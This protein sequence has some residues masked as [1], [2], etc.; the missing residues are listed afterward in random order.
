MWAA[1]ALL[2][3][4]VTWV[5]AIGA[6]AGPAMAGG[7][8]IA[9]KLA[10]A[11]AR[12]VQMATAILY[13]ELARLTANGEA[14]V[15]G[16][17]MRRT[18]RLSAMLAVLLVA[19][20]TLGGSSLIWLLA[21]RSYEFASLFLAILGLAAALELS[22]FAL[23]PLLTAHGR[24]TRVLV[25]RIVGAVAY[26]IALAA[27]LPSAGTAGAAAAAVLSALV[28]RIG[29]GREVRKILRPPAQ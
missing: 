21:G 14:A 28:V 7:Y 10:K 12:P 18:L 16:R 19:V 4:A 20:T 8:R 27:L 6:V 9:A 17:V 11:A 24:P 1:E 25:I 2:Q 13:P 29:L 5:L 3:S 22:G 15:L 26:A 23:A